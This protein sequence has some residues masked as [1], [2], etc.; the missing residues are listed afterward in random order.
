MFVKPF[1][2][3][4]QFREKTYRFK[5]SE[6]VNASDEQLINNLFVTSK[7]ETTNSPIHEFKVLHK[8][9]R[10]FYRLIIMRSS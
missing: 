1:D 6:F 9:Q 10:A 4:K 3:Q 2:G 7:N 8:G 5:D